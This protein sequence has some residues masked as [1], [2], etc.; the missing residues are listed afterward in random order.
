MTAPTAY[1]QIG[2]FVVCFQHAEAAISEILILLA[3]ADDEAVRTLINELDY[4]QRLKTA[5]VMLA[6]FVELQRVPDVSAKTDFHKLIVE[7]GKLGERR[8]ELVHSKYTQWL[9]VEGAF[10]FIRQNSKLRGGKGTREEVEEK[11]LPDAFNEDIENLDR[12]LQR[13][14]VFRLKIINWLYPDVQT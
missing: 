11:L 4:S 9:N 1:H 7:L 3:S 13:L 14:E 2:K 10:G 6:R 5:D 8:N 12:I